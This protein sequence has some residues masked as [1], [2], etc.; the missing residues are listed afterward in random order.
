MAELSPGESRD[1]MQQYIAVLPK[2]E[3]HV[4]LEGAVEPLHLSRLATKHQTALAAGGEQAIQALY[5]TRDFAGFL[6][7]FKIVCQHLQTPVDYEFIT[8]RVL[9]RLSRQQVRYAEIIISAGVMLWNG[10]N[11]VTLFTGIDAGARKAQAEFGIRVQWIFDVVRQFPVEQ[12]WGV[13]RAAAALRSRG[14]VALGIGGD[15]TAAPAER[16]QEIFAFARDHGLH[17]VAHAGE[18]VGPESIW[19]ALNHL[20]AE[21]IGHGLTAA[22]DPALLD[23]IGSRQLP[24]EI[25]LTSNLRTGG[26]AELNQHPLRQY[27]DRGLNVSLHSDDPTLFGTDL[28]R[29]YLLAHEAFGFNQFE[30]RRLAMNSFES[31]FLSRQ[32]KDSCLASFAE[33]A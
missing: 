23:H 9:R 27:F 7:A 11:I 29:E 4:H 16:F 12:A 31:S 20:G 13:A 5:T 6:E 25:C 14:V 19:S 8:Y 10:Q 2:A 22:H 26:I 3:L 30:L 17:L 28:N 1:S 24:V 21:R 18:T 32:E 15:E 33:E